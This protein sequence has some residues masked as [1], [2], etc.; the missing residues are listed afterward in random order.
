MSTSEEIPPDGDIV[1]LTQEDMPKYEIDPSL[2]PGEFALLF[3]KGANGVVL[4]IDLQL[5]QT[6]IG[7]CHVVLQFQNVMPAMPS[8]E[9]RQRIFELQSSYAL[10]PL[11]WSRKALS[12]GYST[13][14]TAGILSKD[15]YFKQLVDAICARESRMVP[16]SLWAIINID[17]SHP[18]HHDKIKRG[19]N[20]RN[21]ISF[22]GGRKRMWFLCGETGGMFGVE[23]PHNAHV[24]LDKIGGGMIGS[25]DHCVELAA[26]TILIAFDSK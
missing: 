17:G 23:V 2:L 25:V 3:R 19:A 21:L 9:I 11:L 5:G 16:F 12:S 20:Y 18:F 14:R 26:N 6:Q 4:P 1:R 10:A 8:S 24:T 13:Q 22:F 7:N 15:A